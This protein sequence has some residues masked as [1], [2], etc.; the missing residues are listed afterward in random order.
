MRIVPVDPGDSGALGLWFELRVAVGRNDVPDF[1][2]PSRREHSGRFEWPWPGMSEE[3]L[4]AWEGDRVV[5]AASYLLPQGENLGTLYLEL[6]VHPEYRRRGVGTGL[7]AEVRAA[8]RRHRRSLIEVE[9]V[10]ALSG[11]VARDEAGYRY[12]TKRDFQP[13][14]TNIRSRCDVADHSNRPQAPAD[15]YSLVQWRDVVPDELIEDFAALQ[16]RLVADAP[17]GDLAVEQ[18]VYDTDRVRRQEATQLGRGH[19]SYSTAARHDATGRIVACTKLS[20]ESDDDAYARQRVTIVEPA[21]RGRGLGLSVKSA[22]HEYAQAHEPALRF[23][24]SWNAEEN[25]HMRAVNATLGFEP[26]DGWSVF[27]L[28]ADQHL[29]SGQSMAW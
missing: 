10:R 11:G 16:S 13:A 7:L 27:Q 5:G 17:T 1:P 8:A 15:G 22:N 9:A 4:L 14:V 25:T 23:I 24:D 6:I 29:A 2:V 21:H 12:L 18:E 28:P 3:A 19:R 20:F 26:V